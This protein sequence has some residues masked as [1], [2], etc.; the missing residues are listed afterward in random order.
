MIQFFFEICCTPR[1]PFSLWIFAKLLDYLIT[2]NE[3]K[4][5]PNCSHTPAKEKVHM[6]TLTN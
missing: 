1:E 5:I 6:E 2:Q 4:A 3:N